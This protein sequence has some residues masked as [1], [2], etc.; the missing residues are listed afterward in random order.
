[1]TE[2]RL[3]RLKNLNGQLREL[4][5]SAQDIVDTIG[6]NAPDA[7]PGQAWPPEL[8]PQRFVVRAKFEAPGKACGDMG[9]GVKFPGG[10]TTVRWLRPGESESWDRIEDMRNQFEVDGLQTVWIDKPRA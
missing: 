8:I 5:T 1:M 4:L 6:D 7:E 2:D 9:L 10:F 3:T